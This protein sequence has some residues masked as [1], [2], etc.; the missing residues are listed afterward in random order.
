[1]NENIQYFKAFKA[2]MISGHWYTDQLNT[3]LKP[4]GLSE[5]RY[6][7]LRL[8]E[9]AGGVAM[10]QQ[11]IQDR[12]IQ[13]SSNVSRIIDKLL[14]EGYV[15]RVINEDNRRKMDICLTAEGRKFLKKVSKK[16]LEF[17][18]GLSDNLSSQEYLQI[19]TLLKKLG[20]SR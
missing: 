7:V 19:A 2:I 13:R 6:N 10:A 14:A 17:H 9:E 1:M 20:S 11:D 5:P 15:S 16:V 3:I 18:G 8:L 4:Y 12:M